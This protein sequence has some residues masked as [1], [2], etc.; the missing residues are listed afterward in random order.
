MLQT[1]PLASNT[2]GRR[3][4]GPL[5]AKADQVMSCWWFVSILSVKLACLLLPLPGAFED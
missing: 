1:L 5:V 3:G 4:Q 2:S